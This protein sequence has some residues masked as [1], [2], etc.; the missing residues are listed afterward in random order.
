MS[1]HHQSSRVIND[2]VLGK[3]IGEGNF[4]ELRFGRHLI[5][6]DLVA[7]KLESIK[8]RAPQLQYEYSFYKR[9]NKDNY[10]NGSK[11]NQV[12]SGSTNDKTSGQTDSLK[13]PNDSTTLA[14]KGDSGIHG[15]DNQ[16]KEITN[17]NQE[18]ENSKETTNRKSINT[19]PTI[20]SNT[21]LPPLDGVP[22][23]YFFGQTSKYN[24]MVMELL[25]PSLEDLFD[26]CH[27][28]F[29]LKTVL[30]ISVQLI[31]RLRYVHSRRLV[32]RDIKPENF[33]IGRWGS[34]KQGK[35]HIIDFGLAKPYI[36]DNT[37]QHIPYREG[38]SLT[39]T[40]RYMSINTHL[41]KEQSRRDDLEAVGHLMM[42]FLRGSLPWQGL[43][44][45]TVKE[46]Y[47]K[48]GETKRHTP[49]ELLCE[50]FPEE[51]ATY[52][53]YVRHIDFFENPDYAYLIKIFVDLY[54][55]KG[56]VWDE[57]FDWHNKTIPSKFTDTPN[58]PPPSSRPGSNQNPIAAGTSSKQYSSQQQ[59]G[60]IQNNP[61]DNHRDNKQIKGQ[62]NSPND[63]TQNNYRQP[64]N[65]PGV[66][67]FQKPTNPGSYNNPVDGRGGHIPNEIVNKQPGINNGPIP[68]MAIGEPNRSDDRCCFCFGGGK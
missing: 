16:S 2:F 20:I 30:M 15:T 64:Q 29:S 21:E 27:R 41:G 52:L 50:G 28:K 48:I 54:E 25:G 43:K 26:I 67:Q 55:S 17:A 38:K 36:D 47:T 59:N 11:S 61:M 62:Y 19:A 24:A 7:V 45:D 1:Q 3:K 35:V 22:K 65:N 68:N 39:G 37:G 4:G 14:S 58:I 31:A 44:A 63:T 6:N 60:K 12:K 34:D 49:I 46:R 32:Y 42:Y 53:R 51:F 23:V 57:K 8:T 66:G 33:V 18:T 13:Q 5:T 10:P 40:A 56:Y 9:L